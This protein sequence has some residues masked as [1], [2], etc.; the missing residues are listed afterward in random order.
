MRITS[1]DTSPKMLK[2]DARNMPKKMKPNGMRNRKLYVIW[3]GGG[4]GGLGP[5]LI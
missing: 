5:M 4:G 1:N 3:D 2:S